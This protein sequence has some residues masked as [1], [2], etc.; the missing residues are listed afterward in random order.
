[1]ATN[2][3]GK[4]ELAMQKRY[5][6]RV[7]SPEGNIV[8]VKRKPNNEH[9][10]PVVYYLSRN[11]RL[12]HPHFLEVPLSSPQGLCLKDVIN[13]LNNLRGDGM[14]NRLAAFRNVSKLS[15]LRNGFFNFIDLQR[16]LRKYG[17]SKDSNVVAKTG[18]KHQS[19]SEFKEL[20]E[21]DH[22]IFVAKTSRELISKG[23]SV[24]TQ[25]DDGTKQG[26][27]GVEITEEH[28]MEPNDL[29][30]FDRFRIRT[31]KF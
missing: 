9:K 19:W 28:E 29:H 11:G 5:Q 22:R 21:V 27:F 1:M 24:S 26:R 18:R 6:E 17:S 30:A 3:R 16:F 23:N 12:E 2:T 7:T 14:A 4:P 25:T 8:W 13:K 10:V 20:D 15:I 31:Q